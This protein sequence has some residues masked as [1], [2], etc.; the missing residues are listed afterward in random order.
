MRYYSMRYYSMRYYSMRYHV[1][2]SPFWYADDDKSVLIFVCWMYGTDVVLTLNEQYVSLY[3]NICIW[4]KF[5]A[6]YMQYEF[7]MSFSC[8]TLL[9]K[10]IIWAMMTMRWSSFV[11]WMC[12][13]DVVCVD[14]KRTARTFVLLRVRSDLKVLLVL[15]AVWG[16]NPTLTICCPN[17][18]YCNV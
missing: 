8:A 9:S 11:G 14:P 15:D 1:V 6:C 16:R 12:G 13:T 3:P 10:Y 5:D 4:L 2:I 18:R 7:V 17:T